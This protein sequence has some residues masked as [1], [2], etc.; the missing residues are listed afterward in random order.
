MIRNATLLAFGVAFVALLYLAIARNLF[1][2]ERKRDRES[3]HF[4]LSL[5]WSD[6]SRRTN[7]LPS[8]NPVSETGDATMS[9]RVPL[10]C[11]AYQVDSPRYTDPLTMVDRLRIEGLGVGV[12]CD[13]EHHCRMMSFSGK[14]TPLERGAIL[15]KHRE[16]KDILILVETHGDSSHWTEPV[17]I[18]VDSIINGDNVS[19]GSE[20]GE[21]MVGFLDGK[22]WRLRKH[23]P[24]KLIASLAKLSSRNASREEM[25]GPYRIGP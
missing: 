23:T 18:S 15:P 25:L 24:R 5:L 8:P 19:I 20:D 6:A 4:I 22:V 13:P 2:S 12:L 17:D 14:D 7:G 10:L 3:M 11:E 16:Y 9:W 1:E 21:I